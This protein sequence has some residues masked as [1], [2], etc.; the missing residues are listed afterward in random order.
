[1][2]KINKT[3]F[4]IGTSLIAGLTSGCASGDKPDKT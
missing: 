3:K 4:I 1:M 2:N